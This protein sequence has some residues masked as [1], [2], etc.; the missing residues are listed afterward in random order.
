MSGDPQ[1]PYVSLDKSSKYDIE[2]LYDYVDNPSVGSE[3]DHQDKYVLEDRPWS[4]GG[5]ETQNDKTIKIQNP[6]NNEPSTLTCSAGRNSWADESTPVRECS[7]PPKR[8]EKDFMAICSNS[9]LEAKHEW[10]SKCDYSETDG[11][12]ETELDFY[13]PRRFSEYRSESDLSL[14]SQTSSSKSVINARDSKKA[15]M[16]LTSRVFMRRRGWLLKRDDICRLLP[17]KML[18]IRPRKLRM[19]QFAVQCAVNGFAH[20]L[21]MDICRYKQQNADKHL[22]VGAGDV[23]KTIREVGSSNAFYRK[24][25]QDEKLAQQLCFDLTETG[26]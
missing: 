15:G 26:N 11:R 17:E 10:D 16:K 23:S 9:L 25:L 21:V 5:S 1:E 2:S 14:P 12:K 4:Y 19:L 24:L 7:S 20:S 8:H 22:S 18:P 6:D 3:Q 13:T